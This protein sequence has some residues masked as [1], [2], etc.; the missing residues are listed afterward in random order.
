MIQRDLEPAIPVELVGKLERAV[1][2]AAEEAQPGSAVLLAPGGASFDQFRDYAHR[3]ERFQEL[4]M[5]LKE[6][7]N[8]S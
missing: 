3:G 1:E 8:E 2:R 7:N 6:T 5:G 4:V